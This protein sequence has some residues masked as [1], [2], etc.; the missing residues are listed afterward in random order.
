MKLKKTILILAVLLLITL[1]GCAKT[2]IIDVKLKNRTMYEGERNTLSYGIHH[3]DETITGYD[4][5]ILFEDDKILFY[6]V[7]SSPYLI[8]SQANN[9][10]N[11][12]EMHLYSYFEALP[13]THN[14]SQDVTQIAVCVYKDEK[15]INCENTAYI[16]IKEMME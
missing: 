7:E 10:Q 14:Y 2:K 16:L 12:G 6:G 4:A 1:S 15:Y 8:N 3:Y 13:F 5:A 9:Y 11:Q